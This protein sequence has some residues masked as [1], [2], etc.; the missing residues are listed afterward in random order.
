MTPADAIQK[1]AWI[2]E[3]YGYYPVEPTPQNFLKYNDFVVDILKD[4]DKRTLKKYEKA[5]WLKSFLETWRFLR[6]NFEEEV[7]RDPTIAYVP[8]HHV[9]KEFHEST[10]DTRYWFSGNRCGKTS[11][12]AIE[13]KWFATGT[14]PYRITP[15]HPCSVLVLA[16]QS[17]S[18][19]APKTFELKYLYGESGNPLFPLFPTDGKW[20][21]HHD[22]RHHTI[23][24]GCPECAAKNKAQSCPSHHPKSKIYLAGHEQP[25]ETLEAFEVG[26]IHIDEHVEEKYYQASKQRRL[27]V[28]RSAMIVTGTPLHGPESWEQRLLVETAKSG[29]PYDEA[30]PEGP[31][32][33]TIHQIDQFS[34]GLSTKAAIENIA[35]DYDYFEYQARVMGIPAAL[36][37]SPVFD[38]IQLHQMVE[39]HVAP[40]E[41]GQFVLRP[42][43]EIE[44]L[45]FF[46]ELEFVETTDPGADEAHDG[47]KNIYTGVRIWEHPQDG[48]DYI[49]G[50]DVAAGLA[51][52][53]RSSAAVI[54]V[55][56]EPEDTEQKYPHIE[57]VAEYYGLINISEYA[58]EIKKLGIYYNTAHVVV[59][60]TGIGVGVMERLRRQ[61][62]YPNLFRD[63]TN[64]AQF[65]VGQ[66]H[67]FGLDTN[68]GT[69]PKMV[70]FTQKALKDGRLVMHCANTIAEF[71]AFE[72]EKTESG[73]NTRYR[74]ASGSRDDRVMAMCLATYVAVTS[75]SKIFSLS[76]E[77]SKNDGVDIISPQRYNEA[78]KLNELLD[79]HVL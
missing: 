27:S 5:G 19:Y 51:G 40:P 23:T 50:A 53:D 42:G 55:T 36:A 75:T 35:R 78:R 21:Y 39:D 34:A 64:P 41:L 65:Q 6:D 61:L 63:M 59:E 52:R 71:T 54:K 69:K 18:T 24:L 74:G 10:A 8:A 3:F 25:L 56:F 72:Q 33:V 60:R 37:K 73:L 9:A 17:L 62:F 57:K 4:C 22:K 20:F 77:A 11:A 68:I 26:L 43:V 45:L 15:G 13:T 44:E 67:S 46:N 32:A 58:D 38:R 7:R 48:A 30:D 47:G 2:V 28:P 31:K 79:G 49:I 66:E 16:G 76:P 29:V 12:G 1:A 70:G 14:H